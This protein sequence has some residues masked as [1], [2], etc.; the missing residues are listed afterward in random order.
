M[1]RSSGLTLLLTSMSCEK[2]V[3]PARLSRILSVEMFHTQ[4]SP[5]SCDRVGETE[6]N[7]S[8]GLGDGGTRVPLK[9]GWDCSLSPKMYL[10]ERLCRSLKTWSILMWKPST[11]KGLGALT[12]TKPAGL[13]GQKLS[14]FGPVVL[15]VPAS[16]VPK[17]MSSPG[18]GIASPGIRQPAPVVTQARAA[19]T[20][21]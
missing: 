15:G 17:T 6:L 11:F 1:P 5:N 19:A 7:M 2:R 20:S 14:R 10:A 3:I 9:A 21:P 16:P 4:P 13:M 12:N 18:P 8:G